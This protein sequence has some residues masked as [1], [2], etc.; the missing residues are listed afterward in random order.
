MTE[1]K[2]SSFSTPS[3]YAEASVIARHVGEHM[4]EK[5]EL[6][7]LQPNRIIDLGC[8]V[9]HCA[10]LL[11]KR[12]PGAT[13]FGVDHAERMLAYA[14]ETQIAEVKWA[15]AEADIL[16][17]QDG[18]VDL[19]F[20]NLLLPWFDDEK[21]IL[22]ECRRIL[23]PEGLLI[24]S[25]LGPDTLIEWQEILGNSLLPNLMD[26]HDSGDALM[27]ARFADPVLD[28]EYLNVTYKSFDKLI[29]E[30]QMTG[31]L[32]DNIPPLQPE[33]NSAGK[34]SV[35]YEIIYGHAW[36]P[37]VTVD[38]I[39]DESGVVKIPLSHLRRR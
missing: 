19:I 38:H 30:L 32:L 28:V 39:A 23:R 12:Y 26:M 20:M 1:K 5:L 17:L 15:C 29:Y 3:A 10:G 31:M 36:G 16:P 13:V 37:D 34:F 9:G 11:Q 21:T 18:S 14:R 6:I 7:T 33:P 35:T 2:L 4:I 8:G 24:F 27:H 22:R 25:S